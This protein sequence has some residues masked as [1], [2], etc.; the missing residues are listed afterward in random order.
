MPTSWPWLLWAVQEPL[1]LPPHLPIHLLL[2]LAGR[3]TA[4][5]HPTSA[6][7]GTCV[8]WYLQV[9][10]NKQ[11][12]GHQTWDVERKRPGPATVSHSLLPQE[13]VG[14]QHQ[15]QVTYV[16]VF[17]IQEIQ[18]QPVAL[19]DDGR[20]Q[21]SSDRACQHCAQPHSHCGHADPLLG[22][23]AE[24]HYFCREKEKAVSAGPGGGVSIWEMATEI[25][26]GAEAQVASKKRKT[27]HQ[28]HMDETYRRTHLLGQAL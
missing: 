11:A 10:D 24:L 9:S 1:A 5:I 3:L 8:F 13:V 16:D 22:G 7:A 28:V 20:P 26:C 2:G 18:G 21:V 19:P 12:G 15:S 27:V 14:A 6:R 25:I 17:Q 23:E 4:T